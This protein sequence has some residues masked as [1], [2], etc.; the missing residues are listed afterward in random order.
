MM[1]LRLNKSLQY[2]ELIP[3]PDC[4]GPTPTFN[5]CYSEYST[6]R[7][8]L[9]TPETT[10]FCCPEFSCGKKFTSDSW[11]LEGIK[12]HHPEH[13]QRN[14]CVCRAPRRVEPAQRGEFDSNT[15]SDENLHAFPYLENNENIANTESQSMPPMPRQEIYPGAGAPQIDYTAE[16]SERDAQGCDETNVQINPY[17]PFVTRKEYKYIHCGINKKGIQTY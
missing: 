13:L 14:L 11:R 3:T 1:V 6:P 12:L 15:D 8:S 2:R 5:P 17:Y 7:V 16:P 9:T 4:S 10:N